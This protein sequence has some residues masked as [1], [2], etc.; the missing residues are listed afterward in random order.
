MTTGRTK[1]DSPSL[2]SLCR[3]WLPAALISAVGVLLCYSI[4]GKTGDI[5]GDFGNDRYIVWQ[6]CQGK[7]LYRDI[8]C[9]YGPLSPTF[10]ALVMRIAGPR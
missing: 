10:N 5:I 6:V 7:L 3:V 1:S 8:A 9:V 2:A 4:W